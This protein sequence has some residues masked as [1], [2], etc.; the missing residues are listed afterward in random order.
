MTKKLTLYHAK[1]CGH[2]V[3]YM[4]EWSTL[5]KT[6]NNMSG[7]KIIIEDYEQTVSPEL[8]KNNNINSFPTL[9]YEVNGVKKNIQRDSDTVIQEL[10]ENKDMKGGGSSCNG[11]K[12]CSNCLGREQFMYKQKYLKYK[13]KYL[14]LSNNRNM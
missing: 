3:N 1:W 13:E 9:V 10:F 5:K 2:C 6:I 8:M 7:G 4:D 12:N 14:Q 11:C